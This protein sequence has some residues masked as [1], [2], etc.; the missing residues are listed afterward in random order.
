VRSRGE[1]QK[2]FSRQEGLYFT[3]PCVK[4][5]LDGK[6]VLPDP[7]GIVE[8]AKMHVRFDRTGPIAL[9]AGLHAIRLEM[10][11]RNVGTGLWQAPSVRLY[12]ES[13]HFL[14]EVIG[15]GALVTMKQEP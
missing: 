15:A 10:D 13:E 11:L 1:K 14:R 8:D 4:L 12:W 3:P 6:Q 5:H 9:E 2:G 7:T